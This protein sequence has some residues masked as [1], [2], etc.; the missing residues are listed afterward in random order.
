[1]HKLFFLVLALICFASG[2]GFAHCHKCNKHKNSDPKIT[3]KELSVTEVVHG[4]V[5]L[6]LS[7]N[8]IWRVK[9]SDIKIA[10]SWI[11]AMNIV[12]EKGEDVEYPYK[13]TNT[14]SKKSIKVKV[15][16]EEEIEQV[17]IPK[18]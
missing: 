13:L 18:I 7:D 15:S 10:S 5:F 1:M 17:F 8:S 6:E 16:S 11:V 12:V 14:L 2:E 3:G 9:P 4:G